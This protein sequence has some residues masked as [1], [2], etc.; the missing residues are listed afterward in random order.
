MS[1][2][3]VFADICDCCG[4]EASRPPEYQPAEDVAEDAANW[5]TEASR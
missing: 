2:G 3:T 5:D 1:T 4:T